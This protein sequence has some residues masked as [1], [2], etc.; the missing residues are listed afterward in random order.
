MRIGIITPAPP[1][2]RYGNRVT[3]LRWA[4]LLKELGHRVTIAN[5]YEGENFDLLIALHARRSYPAI[6]RFHREQRGMP[7]I[8]AL[9][10]PIFTAI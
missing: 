4:R 9:T 10:G 5:A 3:A 8:V 2:S 7:I 6:S 1:R